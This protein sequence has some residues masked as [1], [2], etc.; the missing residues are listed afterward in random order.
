M[1]NIKLVALLAAPLFLLTACDP[2]SGDSTTLGGPISTKVTAANYL[3]GDQFCSIYSSITNQ[4]HSRRVQV[5]KDYSNP[6]QGS[7]SLYVWTPKP[8]DASKPTLIVVNGGP[9]QNSHDKEI[10]QFGLN[11]FNEINFDQRGLGCSAPESFEEYQNPRL[12]STAN[13]VRDMDLIRKAYGVSSWSV[14]GISYGTIPAT[15]YASKFT[16]STRSVVLEG[17]VGD[18]KNLHRWSYKAEKANLMIQDFSYA[19]RV[20]LRDFLSEQTDESSLL[21]Q[22][23]FGP[24]FMAD[25]GQSIGREFMNKIFVNGQVNRQALQNLKKILSSMGGESYGHAQ[26][27]GAVDDTILT[28]IYCKEL[29]YKAKDSSTLDYSVSQGFFESYSSSRRNAKACDEVGVTSDMENFYRI[30]NHPVYNP[31]YYFQ[32]SH[33]GATMAVS[34]KAHWMTVPK[35]NSYFMLAQ[36]GGHNPALS[37]LDKEKPALRL[38]QQNLFRRAFSAQG[39]GAADLDEANRHSASN[40]KWILYTNPSSATSFDG[41][42]V[43]ILRRGTAPGL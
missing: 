25:G 41:E 2:P 31:I 17:V 22:F 7:L 19:N 33:D 21:V 1:K 37:R 11:E 27:P 43:G 3:N 35:G 40:R 9:G 38:A 36:K 4:E 14:Y 34:A 8:F 29:D 12:Y 24:I 5:P 13:T 15:Q 42:L 23:I 32:G 28:T 6:E 16:G 20:A 30:Q 10:G 26:Y 18:T 39:I